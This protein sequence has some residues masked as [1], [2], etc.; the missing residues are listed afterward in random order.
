[1]KNSQQNISIPVGK[2]VMKI[3]QD[4]IN[5]DFV[6]GSNTHKIDPSDTTAFSYHIVE[7]VDNNTSKDI[8]V[9]F[10]INSVQCQ[11]FIANR[12]C[13][14]S[15]GTGSQGSHYVFAS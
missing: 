13:S 1:M 8:I 11:S 7:T 2:D 14:G 5:Q 9:P 6:Y 12:V 4:A 15:M 3:S 10:S